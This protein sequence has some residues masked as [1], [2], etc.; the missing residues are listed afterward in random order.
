MSTRLYIGNLGYTM[1]EA[2]LTELFGQVGQVLSA[3]IITDRATGQSRGFG[4]VEMADG[5]AGREAIAR[6]NGHEIDGR[7]IKVAEAHPRQ[8]DGQ[9]RG[10]E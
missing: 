8:A 7:A 6:L 10:T 3:D 5:S 2:A 9:R 1:T 4:F